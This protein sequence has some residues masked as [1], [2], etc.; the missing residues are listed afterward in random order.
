MT[1]PA[2]LHFLVTKAFL[3]K[4]YLSDMKGSFGVG[5][6]HDS[7]TSQASFSSNSFGGAVILHQVDSCAWES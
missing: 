4:V 1:S 2:E 6:K 5:V 7:L 3:G